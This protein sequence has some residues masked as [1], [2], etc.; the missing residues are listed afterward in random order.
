MT[1]NDVLLEQQMEKA[2][3]LDLAWMR[4]Q[5]EAI[6]IDRAAHPRRGPLAAIRHATAAA[7]VRVSIWLDRR[8][9]ERAF[10]PSAQ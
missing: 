7:L 4:F 8:A 2:R 3:K 10:T 5:E 6:R 9:G 1:F